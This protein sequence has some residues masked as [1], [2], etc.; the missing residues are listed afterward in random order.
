[1]LQQKELDANKIQIVLNGVTGIL[2]FTQRI[3]LFLIFLKKRH[4]HHLQ[5]MAIIDNF[6]LYYQMNMR[7]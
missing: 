4:F 3:H 1:M 5:N 7:N 6:G 2:Q